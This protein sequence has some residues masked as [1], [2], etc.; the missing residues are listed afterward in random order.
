MLKSSGHF[1]YDLLTLIAEL[2]LA[3]LFLAQLLRRLN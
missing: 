2:F 3:Q 1:Y